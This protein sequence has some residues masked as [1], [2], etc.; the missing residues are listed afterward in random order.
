MPG[1]NPPV[2]SSPSSEAMCASYQA[3]GPVSGWCELMMR[4]VTPSPPRFGDT[5]KAFEPRSDSVF[6]AIRK[7]FFS[8]CGSS[9]MASV[10]L[11]ENSSV[12]VPSR[13]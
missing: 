11:P 6:G 13:P 7:A 9:A 12:S 1:N 4:R 8:P 3:T 2:M 10:W 5:A